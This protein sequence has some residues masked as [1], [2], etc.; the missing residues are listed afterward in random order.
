MNVAWR[1][2]L[3][4]QV[5]EWLPSWLLPPPQHNSWHCHAGR[6]RACIHWYQHI[7]TG[8]SLVS[9]TRHES[10]SSPVIWRPPPH[11]HT[12][13]STLTSATTHNHFIKQFVCL[14]MRG[15]IILRP[16]PPL[17]TLSVS[18]L[19]GRLYAITA[20][21]RL[22]GSQLTITKWKTIKTKQSSVCRA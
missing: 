8:L 16:P 9:L 3:G 5:E 15:V 14:V 11:H 10:L 4:E 6:R 21:N 2:N 19:D 20:V 1:G 22:T 7:S 18:L 12:H 17:Q 13:L